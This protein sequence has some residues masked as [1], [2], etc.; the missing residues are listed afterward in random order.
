MF[1]LSICYYWGDGRLKDIAAAIA[2]KEQAA[3]LGHKGAQAD[4]A[5][6]YVDLDRE[7][8]LYWAQ[9]AAANG[10][11]KAKALMWGN[12]DRNLVPDLRWTDLV[13]VVVMI[14]WFDNRLDYCD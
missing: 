14:G 4:L 7:K 6:I 13:C 12:G 8:Y 9:K 1:N 2:W 11:V 10:S 5:A 3:N